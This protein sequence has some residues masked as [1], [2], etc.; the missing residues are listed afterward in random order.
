MSFKSDLGQ[1]GTDLFLQ[2]GLDDPN[3]V[4]PVQQIS[5]LAQGLRRR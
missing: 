5:V 1:T 3:H 2:M 4:D